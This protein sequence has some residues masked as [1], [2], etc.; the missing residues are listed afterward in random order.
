MTTDSP[1]PLRERYQ[2]EADL[3]AL[4]FHRMNPGGVAGES[5]SMIGYRLLADVG[6]LLERLDQQTAEIANQKHRLAL[7]SNSVACLSTD[8]DD[9]RRTIQRFRDRAEQAEAELAAAQARAEAALSVLDCGQTSGERGCCSACNGT[10]YS[11]EEATGGQCSD[12]RATGHAHGPVTPDGI[13]PFID[14]VRRALAGDAARPLPEPEQPQ[15]LDVEQCHCGAPVDKSIYR[16]R[17]MC[18]RCDDVRCDA[19]PGE[20][21]NDV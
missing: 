15:D 9:A 10:G 7:A 6:P 19:Y 18:T 21:R 1:E 5:A 4:E 2:I 13:G 17:G 16:D 8:R 20:C 3:S 11:G 14:C 12:C